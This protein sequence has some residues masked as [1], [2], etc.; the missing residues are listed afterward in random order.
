MDRSDIVK[1]LQEQPQVGSDLKPLEV[2]MV[3]QLAEEAGDLQLIASNSEQ[4]IEC[5]QQMQHWFAAKEREARIEMADASSAIP[6]ATSAGFRSGPFER[7]LKRAGRRAEFYEKAR[8]AVAAGYTIIPAFPVDVFAIR[9][10]RQNPLRGESGKWNDSHEQRSESPAAGEGEYKDSIP[11]VSQRKTKAVDSEGNQITKYRHFATEFEDVI[12]FPMSLAKAE[13]MESAQV[14]MALKV[15]DEIGVL[16][17][18]SE[19]KKDPLLVGIIK[20]HRRP[21]GARDLMFLIAWYMDTRT[22]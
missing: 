18:R 1:P 14:A 8:L 19:K 4:M 22:L 3:A 2:D 16:P 9:T 15:F 12:D 13:I 10:K 21:N 17:E 5:Q 20:D 6:L 7:Q 11:V